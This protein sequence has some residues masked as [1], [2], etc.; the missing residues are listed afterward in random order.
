[1]SRKDTMVQ[2]LET[3]E[4]A[5]FESGYHK[6]QFEIY[7]GKLIGYRRES[8]KDKKVIADYNFSVEESETI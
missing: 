4:D 3:Y 6:V 8:G 7:D 5:I 1:M 2:I